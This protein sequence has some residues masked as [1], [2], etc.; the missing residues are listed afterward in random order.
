MK[1]ITS[2]LC[3]VVLG[4]CEQAKPVSS[5][6]T[7]SAT[8]TLPNETAIDEIAKARCA[9]ETA[10]NNVG[11]Q[12]MWGSLDACLRDQRDMAR[13]AISIHRCPQGVDA[14]ALPEC[15]DAIGREACTSPSLPSACLKT[16]L[17]L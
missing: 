8:V 12:R 1:L 14:S 9:R 7:T 13:E 11:D 4:A 2:A 15:M 16:F 10:C 5:T 3:I 17:C 6:T